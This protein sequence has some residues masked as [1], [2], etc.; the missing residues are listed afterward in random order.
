MEY[1][2]TLNGN[3]NKENNYSAVK[4]NSPEKGVS[5]VVSDNKLSI[6]KQFVAIN[7]RLC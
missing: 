5:F 3:K 2:W 4:G 1:R 6:T 7:Y